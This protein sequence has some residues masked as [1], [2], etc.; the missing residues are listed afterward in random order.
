MLPLGLALLA[1]NPVST[2]LSMQ[3]SSIYYLTLLGALVML[4]TESW[5][6][7]WGYLVFL[8]LGV[9]TAFFDFLTYPACAVG[10]CLGLQALMS[11]SSGRDRLLKTIG[12]GTAPRC[13]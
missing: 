12:S 11:Q 1:I 6:R 7:N 13:R 2:A 4:L 8:F 9:G 10:I 3:Y 5:D